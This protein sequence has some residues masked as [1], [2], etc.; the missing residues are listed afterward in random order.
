[1][2]ESQG[3][4]IGTIRKP[5]VT[6]DSK[7]G[8]TCNINCINMTMADTL[9]ALNLAFSSIT[10]QNRMGVSITLPNVC[11]VH[12]GHQILKVYHPFQMTV[13]LVRPEMSTF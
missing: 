6:S 1:M 11:N 13:K 10:S 7:T 3:K 9:R 12:F 2:K 5:Y 8:F 4:T